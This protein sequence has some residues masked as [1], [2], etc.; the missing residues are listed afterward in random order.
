MCPIDTPSES[1]LALTIN[2][3]LRTTPKRRVEMDGGLDAS[4]VA[5]IVLASALLAFIFPLWLAVALLI[6]LQDDGP[7]IFAHRRLGRGGRTF[8]CLKFRSMVVDADVR[9]A[10][11]LQRDPQA[12]AEWEADHKLR[13]D[14]RV[15]PLGDFLRRSSIDE[16]PQLLNVLRGEMSLVGPRPIVGAEVTRYGRW[17]N[18]YCAV[19]PGLSG[20]WQVSGRNDVSYR[21]RVALD[22][23]YAS[24]RSFRLYLYILLK[25]VPAV[26]TRDGSY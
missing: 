25:T 14:P 22:R 20:L 7:V 17:F 2:V 16:L 10:Q 23:L 1:G 12:R 15:T 13:K 18:A 5:D 9:L 8:D 4:R 11:L 26:L 19:R 24:R 6:K 3:D 21:R